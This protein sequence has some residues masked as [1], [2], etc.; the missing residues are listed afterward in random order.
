MGVLE[1]LEKF[2]VI[3]EIRLMVF[4][5]LNMFVVEELVKREILKDIMIYEE[6]FINLLVYFFD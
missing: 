2:E 3:D 5:N 4:I 6:I 1:K